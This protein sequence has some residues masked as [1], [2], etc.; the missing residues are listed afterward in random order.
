MRKLLIVGSGFLVLGIF[1]L[2]IGYYTFLRVVITIISL[3]IIINENKTKID[4][5]KIIFLVIL[6]LFNPII[7]IYLYNKGIWIVIDII[8]ALLFFLKFIL[9]KGEG[10]SE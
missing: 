1:D 6:I 8:V 7:P 10:V 5:W 2:P 3:L 9:Q 4:F